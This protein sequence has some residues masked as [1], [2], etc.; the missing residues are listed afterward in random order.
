M[1]SYGRGKESNARFVEW[2]DGSMTLHVGNE[3]LQVKKEVLENNSHHLFVKHSEAK[4]EGEAPHECAIIESHGV[5]EARMVIKKTEHKTGRKILATV[6]KQYGKK[7][8]DK[9]SI[10]VRNH[11]DDAS[12]AA[13]V[14]PC[15]R[16]LAPSFLCA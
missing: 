15:Q 12:L 5:L 13:Q 1:V 9:D 16:L 4:V 2:S 7:Q 6:S 10:F 3:V 11:N 14:S 8:L